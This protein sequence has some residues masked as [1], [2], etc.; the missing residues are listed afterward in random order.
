MNI[1][2]DLGWEKYLKPFLYKRLPD[3]T[4]WSAVLG[5]MCALTFMLL[6]GDRH[7]SGLLLCAIAG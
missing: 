3:G 6:V 7:D 5:T 1:R 4:G 2:S